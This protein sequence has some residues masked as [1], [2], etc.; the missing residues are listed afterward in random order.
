E[1]IVIGTFLRGPNWNFFGPFEYWDVNKIEPLV[2]VDLSE[3][4]W[5]KV[6][7]VGL[8]GHWLIREAPGLLL[9]LA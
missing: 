4:F 2:N 9:V 5:I 3:M 7:G 1:L 6:L 8:P